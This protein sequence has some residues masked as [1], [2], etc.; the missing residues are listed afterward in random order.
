M[1]TTTHRRQEPVVGGRQ[2]DVRVKL[3]VEQYEELQRRAAE[4]HVTVQRLLVDGALVPLG[5]PVRALVHE[6]LSQRL[7]LQNLANSMYLLA[8]DGETEGYDVEAHDLGAH[9]VQT[10]IAAINDTLALVNATLAR[11]R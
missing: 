9:E 3:T 7:L 8:M 6:L 4:Q 1:T 10:G 2:V 11:G 5:P